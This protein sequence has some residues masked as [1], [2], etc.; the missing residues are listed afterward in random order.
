[1]ER[2]GATKGLCLYA[3][4]IKDPATFKNVVA[5]V[6]DIYRRIPA[7]FGTYKADILMQMK[8][9]LAKKEAVLVS[10][11]GNAELSDQIEWLKNQIK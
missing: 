11:P 5:P 1:M 7:G 8:G 2:I 3:A 4:K 6:M 9:L 10:Q